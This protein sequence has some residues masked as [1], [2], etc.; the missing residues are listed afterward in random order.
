MVLEVFY[1]AQTREQ[2]IRDAKQFLESPDDAEIDAIIE[3][4]KQIVPQDQFVADE[5]I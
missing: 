2:F 4:V 5:S 1:S 3:R